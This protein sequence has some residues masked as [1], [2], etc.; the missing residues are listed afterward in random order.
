MRR[1]PFQRGT[2]RHMAG[3]DALARLRIRDDGG[4]QS[5]YRLSYRQ[6]P[7]SAQGHP[8]NSSR[9]E[10]DDHVVVLAVVF[11]GFGRGYP[12]G[13][14]EIEHQIADGGE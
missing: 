11:T 10:S 3:E 5:Y 12:S 8:K 1:R 4:P 9:D 6:T 13:A 7:I 2:S 14:D